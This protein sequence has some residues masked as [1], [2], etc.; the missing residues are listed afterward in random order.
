MERPL[1]SDREG[2]L[3]RG[4]ALPDL[5][6]ALDRESSRPLAAQLADGLRAAAHSG[7]LR[8]GDR[9]PSTRALARTLGLSRTVTAAAYDQVNAE[10]W[11]AGWHGSGT[12]VVAA[13]AEP[14]QPARRA[15]SPRSPATDPG[16]PDLRPG[17]PWSAALRTAAWRR[18][19]RAAADAA[20]LDR[21]VRAGVADFRS[22][23]AEHLLRHR[24]LSVE[25]SAVL[26]TG[27]TT[28]ALGELA[29]SV[30]AP[31]D[32]VVVEEPGYPRAAG[33]LRAAGLRVLPTPVDAEGL[34]V[35]ELPGEARAVYCTPSHQF[36]L[37]ARMPADRRLELVRWARERGAWV[38]ED[39]YDG[40]LRH[41]GAPLPLLASL[42]PD[43]VVHLGTT[44]KILTPT[45]G[46]GWMVAPGALT[47][48]VCD[49]REATGTG[50]APAGQRVLVELARTG[51]LGRHLRRVR[52]EL[53]GRRDLLTGALRPAGLGVLGDRAGAH[54]VVP[55]PS[56]TAERDAVDAAARGGI[57]LDSLARC[58]IDVAAWHG[59]ILGY[60]APDTRDELAAAMASLVPLLARTGGGP[61]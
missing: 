24:G 58:H 17:T 6:L 12:F 47:A 44:S 15:L 27:G 56:A 18:A 55:L 23:V 46:V 61:G 33:A 39:D 52:R 34:V 57:A 19:W 14:V 43:I 38:I 37:G 29:S 42:G 32:V 30:L 3:L 5:P 54:L 10:G 48:A 35:A 49:H 11:I 20:P 36:P 28:A 21:P 50:P 8:V 1:I 40:E 13:P 9:L 25:P 51:D 45:L 4:S 26:A 16:G 59:L 31:G 2:P 53:L 7:A 41:D 22:A 60:A